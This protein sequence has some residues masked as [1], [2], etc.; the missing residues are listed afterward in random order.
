MLMAEADRD[1]SRAGLETVGRTCP[2][3]S[4]ACKPPS[5]IKNGLLPELFQAANFGNDPAGA[6]NRWRALDES[7]AYGARTL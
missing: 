3:Q 5:V 1:A 7:A 2:P 6:A 4:S